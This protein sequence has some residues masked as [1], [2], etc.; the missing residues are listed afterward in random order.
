MPLYKPSNPSTGLIRKIFGDPMSESTQKDYPELAR[1]WASAQI[2]MPKETKNVNR[3]S[4]N[5]TNDAILGRYTGILGEVDINKQANEQNDSLRNTL[6]HEITHAN[7]P[8]SFK[9]FA[10]RFT[11]PWDKRD[12][13]IEAEDKA[14][15][16]NNPIREHR[17]DN[18]LP[19]EKGDI[20]DPR[21][22]SYRTDPT[23]E[24]RKKLLASKLER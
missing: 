3:V 22:A 12:E 5:I 4:A 23:L 15:Y 13:E 21:I 17:H 1:A 8:S 20:R 19:L 10:Q 16:K 24:H 18:Y 6:V 2:R 14:S 11:Q 9:S 7:R